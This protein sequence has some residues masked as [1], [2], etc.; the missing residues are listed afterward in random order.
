MKYTTKEGIQIECSVEEYQQ[1]Q[2]LST[3]TETIKLEP[4]E[5]PKEDD[6]TTNKY[7]K[8]WSKQEDELLKELV[9][10]KDVNKIAL[11]LGRTRASVISR[12]YSKGLSKSLPIGQKNVTKNSFDYETENTTK[13][14]RHWRKD[15]DDFLRANS[16]KTL[17]ELA[18]S[19]GRTTIA[20]SDRMSYLKIMRNTPRSKRMRYVVNRANKLCNQL[21]LSYEVA[22]SRAHQEYT[23]K[24]KNVG[25]T[26]TQGVFPVIYPLS[27]LGHKNLKPILKHMI[28][29]SGELTLNEAS[30]GL[31]LVEG[32]EWSGV[33]WNGFLNY[34]ITKSADVARFFGVRN[35]F[36]IVNGVLHYG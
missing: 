18:A 29:N 2:R 4:S 25:V 19:L 27:Q 34:F 8:R 35:R 22:I 28:D 36:K 1:L 23:D 11:M 3:T 26:N 32:V 24:H 17:K 7:Y 9:G 20:I 14:H 10:K 21:N 15:E 33:T 5:P 13:R 16:D 31:D 12:C 6:K 30:Q